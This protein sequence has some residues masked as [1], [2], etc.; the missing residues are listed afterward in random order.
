MT[1]IDYMTII[2]LA[3]LAVFATVFV[4]I[5]SKLDYQHTYKDRDIAAPRVP[6]FRWK[7]DRNID[8][9]FNPML[10]PNHPEHP[11]YDRRHR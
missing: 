11:F 2:T 10:N 7:T 6:F 5:I 1:Y 4:R 3:G 9:A 8:D